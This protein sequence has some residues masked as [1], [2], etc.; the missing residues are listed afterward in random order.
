M[1]AAQVTSVLERVRAGEPGAKQQLFELV[2]DDLRARAGRL[3]RG[4]PP[5]HTLQATA[6]AHEGFLRL[7]RNGELA[8]E[9]RRHLMNALS[10]AM[11]HVLLDHAK[12]KQTAKRGGDRTRIPLAGLELELAGVRTDV[13]DVRDVL[14]RLRE[15]EPRSEEIVRLRFFG[16][17][18]N[19]EIA[20]ILGMSTR[21]V[22]REWKSLRALLQRW[23]S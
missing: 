15:R 23:L 8:V 20:A 5:G 4:Q 9:N 13:L 14:D 10:T 6:L 19:S 18:N 17:F 1:S 7:T 11:L 16:G 21:S 22:E 12:A 2:Y 3:M